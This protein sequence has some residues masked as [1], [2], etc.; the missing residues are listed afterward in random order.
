MMDKMWRQPDEHTQH[1]WQQ[2]MSFVKPKQ[3]GGS[4]QLKASAMR[5]NDIAVE[6]VDPPSPAARRSARF[7]RDSAVAERQQR[8]HALIRQIQANAMPNVLGRTLDIPDPEAPNGCWHLPVGHNDPNA[9][10]LVVR[11]IALL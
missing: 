9:Q 7:Y 10:D 1:R 3:G 6:I 11:L 4:S 2:I 5:P 8:K